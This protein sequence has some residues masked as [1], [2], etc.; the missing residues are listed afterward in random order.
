MYAIWTIDEN[1][2]FKLQNRWDACKQCKKW[3][4]SSL[5]DGQPKSG[6]VNSSHN[7]KNIIGSSAVTNTDVNPL[8]NGN[9]SVIGSS[10]VIN[11]DV[12]SSYNG[13][14]TIGMSAIANTDDVLLPIQYI[15]VYGFTGALVTNKFAVD[16]HILG[17]PVSYALTTVDGSVT[18]IH[19]LIY[20]LPLMNING[21]THIINALGIDKISRKI[22]LS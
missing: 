12:N 15:D 11:T 20:A 4:A 7:A 18:I 16:D 8:N 6:N 5:C 9:T 3:H 1:C 22:K 10:A 19:S 2:N 17:Y 21:N 14:T 13:K